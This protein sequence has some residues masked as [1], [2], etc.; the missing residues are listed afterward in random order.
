MWKL[1]FIKQHSINPVTVEFAG[2]IESE[3]N[4]TVDGEKV[5][6][7]VCVYN[8]CQDYVGWYFMLNRKFA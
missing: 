2:E 3:A 1:D 6:R 5:R 4:R 8:D 7:Y